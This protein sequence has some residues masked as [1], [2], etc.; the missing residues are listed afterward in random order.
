MPATLFKHLEPLLQKSA[1][2]VEN[3]DRLTGHLQAY[4]ANGNMPVS[5]LK[6]LIIA[7]ALRQVDLRCSFSVF[8][9]VLCHID[10]RSAS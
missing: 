1:I 4:P 3:A 9:S 7:V 6:V 10:G 2:N 5:A 8:L